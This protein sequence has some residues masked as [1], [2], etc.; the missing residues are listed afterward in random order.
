MDLFEYEE[1][2]KGIP[3]GFRLHQLEIWNW[4][5]FHGAI[6]QL[7][8]NGQTSLLTGENGS[9]KS[10]L[11]D[12]LI[13][14]LVPNR[15]RSYN[16]AAGASRKRE[17]SEK[18]YIRGAY[19]ARQQEGDYRAATQ[20]L[21]DKNSYSVLLAHFRNEGYD[22]DI[23]LAQVLWEED[24]VKKFFVVA[25]RPLA[26]TT[27]FSQF[28]TIR[29]L[30]KQLR[31]LDGVF[32][33]DQFKQYSAKFRKLF[34]LRSDKA[35][36]L[37]N[38][39]VT[40]KEIGQLND[41]VRKHMLEST[42]A[43]EKVA[44]LQSHYENLF[45]AYQAIEKAEKQLAILRPLVAEARKYEKAYA[46]LQQLEGCEQ[47]IP[48]YFA[49]R[50]LQLLQQ[51]IAE[52]KQQTQQLQNQTSAL[53][54]QIDALRQQEVALNIAI[55]NDEIG[56]QINDLEQ[57]RKFA[58]H[59]Q[60]D[61]QVKARDYDQL[62]QTF[63]LPAYADEGAFYSALQEA[64]TFRQTIDKQKEKVANDLAQLQIA[65]DKLAVTAKELGEELQSLKG[66]TSQ[67]PHR[68][69]QTRSRIL[70]A[71]NMAEW[72]VPFVGELLQV[73]E[74]EALWEGAIERLLHNF[75]LR[76]LVPE[77][78]Y[79]RFV[80][81]VNKTN[82][83]GRIVF[84]RVPEE[85]ERVR[86]RPG[87]SHTLINKLQV[88]PQPNPYQDWIEKEL[89]THY[90]YACCEDM[91]DFR[92]AKRA[93]T[94]AGLIKSA[95]QRHEKDDRHSLRDRRR[96]V[97]GWHNQ[98]KIE[99]LESD[100]AHVR[101]DLKQKRTTIEQT[102]R[103]QRRAFE[104]AKRLEDFLKYTDFQ[105][106]NWRQEAQEVTDLSNQIKRLEQSSDQ[107]NQLQAELKD[108]RQRM[109]TL[110]LEKQEKKTRIDQFKLKQKEHKQALS[111]CHKELAEVSNDKMQIYA[112][113]IQAQVQDKIDL[114][115][116]DR[117]W[118][119]VTQHFRGAIGSKER[120]LSQHRGTLTRWM[121]DYQ[122]QFPAE[123]TEFDIS[124]KAI[125]EYESEHERIAQDDLPQY[126]QRF[127]TLLNEK[128]TENIV[129][130]NADLN[131][132]QDNIKEKIS[133]LNRSL[134]KIDYTEDT[135]IEL[136]TERNPDPAIRDFQRMLH[137]CMPDV[138]RAPDDNTYEE[139]FQQVR[140][141]VTRL[142]E[143][144][145][146]TNKVTD[147]RHW[148]NFAAV[149]R[150]RADDSE[151]H[152]YS[153]SSGKSGGQKAKLAY[154]ILASAIAYQ[155]GLEIGETRSKS[156][157]FVVVDEAFSRSDERNSHYAME[158]FE[159]L[160]LQLLVVT[161]KTGIHIV[162]PFIKVCHIVWNNPDGDSS[163][164]RNLSIQAFRAEREQV[165]KQRRA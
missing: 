16:Q 88:K 145:Y 127:K 159:K 142:K 39:T 152:Y 119:Q 91:G 164:V 2:K 157:R 82:L 141:L 70:D 52:N 146:W 113:L 108:T 120:G 135:Y 94:P 20:Y 45:V 129:I 105:Q 90:D 47:A 106:I 27:H 143:E 50:K 21:R 128:V 57:Q 144:P 40:I 133:D 85:V 29:A 137:N 30:K 103:Q 37:F 28:D 18:T 72:D 64:Q 54:Q 147:V 122:R 130:L 121:Q 7:C 59:I 92:R 95:G 96:Y 67:I 163:Q 13:T 61:K 79:E 32:L 116:V 139:S 42:D 31:S 99:A 162:E 140:E 131:S 48:V 3:A 51:A 117:L 76:L 35:L 4:G 6:W 15:Q 49:G 123:T 154:T 100:L 89:S 9:G 151:Y 86:T 8:P 83:R 136:K 53:A 114:T 153:D 165:N 71:L 109:R 132:Y 66:R 56:R 1:S 14:L 101:R 55:E 44:Q 10:T 58:R 104:Q 150:Y 156:F 73:K 38:Q 74:S 134:R 46:E 125:P 81:Y 34:G 5:T 84:H 25:Q 41:F 23:T 19:G 107:L 33:T 161:P 69:L 36:D 97:L 43:R 24:K 149:E 98:A 11:V 87:R 17:R 26:I 93:I 102:Q 75:G 77:R 155:F 138:G 111:E 12:A 160:N 68:I 118:R 110:S 115:N 63:K 158:L 62:A 80:D 78:H 22:E 124:V 112:P 148:L 126:R 65:E 60:S